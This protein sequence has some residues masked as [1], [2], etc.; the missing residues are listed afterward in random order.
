MTYR[1]NK[2]NPLKAEAG[3]L[4]EK[5]TEVRLEQENISL[6]LIQKLMRTLSHIIAKHT[7]T[8]MSK[9]P[10]LQRDGPLYYANL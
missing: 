3:K 9:H 10:H 7:H 1:E 8:C 4:K 2:N 6:T 5:G